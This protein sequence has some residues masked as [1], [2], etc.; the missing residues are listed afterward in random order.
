M[1]IRSLSP[2]H[3]GFDLLVLT[4]HHVAADQPNLRFGMKSAAH[5]RRDVLCHLARAQ[6][7]RVEEAADGGVAL[8]V[9]RVSSIS[10]PNWYAS[11]GRDMIMQRKIQTKGFRARMGSLSGTL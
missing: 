9:W 2:K 10:D 5:E 11:Q 7:S 3:S 6:D 4:H 8:L 1:E